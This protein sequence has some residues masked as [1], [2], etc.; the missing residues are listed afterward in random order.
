MFKNMKLATKI[1]VGF[2]L[3]LVFLV[4]VGLTGYMSLNGTIGQME[5]IS[6]QLE[7][8]KKVNDT[9]ALSQEILSNVVD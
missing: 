9:L 6:T 1:I 2:G 5:A 4:V 3:V 8:A 7:I